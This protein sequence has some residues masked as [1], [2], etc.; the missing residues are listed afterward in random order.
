[1]TGVRRTGGELLHAPPMITRS[2]S[3][4]GQPPGYE[5]RPGFR[6]RRRP[7]RRSARDPVRYQEGRFCPA[8]GSPGVREP[9]RC[10]RRRRARTARGPRRRTPGAPTSPRNWPSSTGM[11]GPRS[12]GGRRPAAGRTSRAGARRE[13]GCPSRSGSRAARSD[14]DDQPTARPDRAPRRSGPGRALRGTRPTVACALRRPRPRPA[15]P[16]WIGLDRQ[17]HWRNWPSCDTGPIPCSATLRRGRAAGLWPSHIH[18]IWNCHP[19]RRMAPRLR[20]KRRPG[21]RPRVL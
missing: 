15:A 6:R 16:S 11:V 3:T 7:G 20:R 2:R 4:V 1:M 5:R 17:A 13:P 18:A 19:G 21:P 10:R 14:R 8:T 12:A 9:A